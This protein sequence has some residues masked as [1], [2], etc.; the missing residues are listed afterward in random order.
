MV[1]A[2]VRTSVTAV[3][4]TWF[5]RSERQ[6][7]DLAPS[8][9]CAVFAG[10]TLS[11][12]SPPQN[13]SARHLRVRLAAPRTGCAFTEGF[14]YAPHL[15]V[16]T[17]VVLT[18]TSSTWLKAEPVQS[19]SLDDDQRCVLGAREMLELSGEPQPA[20]GDHLRVELAR[21]RS[22]CALGSGYIYGPHF[23]LGGLALAENPLEVR[24]FYQYNNRN[25]P[26]GTCGIT[27]G[28]MLLAA[29]GSTLTPDDLYRRYGKRQGQS[30]TG[31]ASIYRSELGYGQ[32]SYAGTRA[33]IRRHIDEGRPI[34]I[35]GNFTGSG[36]I[37]MVVGYDDT[38]WILH[39]P[40]GRWAGCYRCGYPSSTSTNGRYVHYSYSSMSASVIGADGNVW[41]SVGSTE[42][43]TF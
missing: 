33:Q 15:E 23:D 29:H 22:G 43:F 18:A 13:G 28:A 19:S 12:A 17:T 30:P 38:G 27:S 42:P 1:D 7:G 34:V 31:L 3:V 11:L 24:Y 26:G 40:A 39:D 41:M 36:H 8:D 4:N 25:E 6:S 9:L 32:G 10:E 37:M 14:L 21:P 2:E 20:S 16:A 5:K 35:H